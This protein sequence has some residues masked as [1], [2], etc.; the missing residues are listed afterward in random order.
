MIDRRRFITIGV[1]AFVVAGLPV[2]LTRRRQPRT[3][4]RS[5]PVMGT[6]A[7]LVV[8]H[9]DVAKA[10][11]AIDAAVAELR[12]VERTMTR[13]TATSDIGRA[14]AG[15][16]QAAVAVSPETALVV[17][18]ALRWADATSGAYDPAIGGVI[19]LWD[20]TNRQSPP[21]GEAIVAL[22]G[23][24]LHRTVE[25]G[26]GDR[27]YFHDRRARLDLGGI[28]KGYGVDRAVDALRANGI[29]RAV[30]DVGGDLY[31]LG[32]AADDEPWSIGIQSPDDRRALA[33]IIPASDCAIATSGTYQQFFRFR[34]ERYHHLIDPRTAAPRA[35]PVQSLTIR[36]DSCMHADVAATALYGMTTAT[37]N[38]LLARVAF[39]ARVERTI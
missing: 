39:D 32:L 20:V 19:G 2:A 38:A 10:E 34:G 31:A 35:T 36:A 4:R 33:A 25:V 37:A 5:I 16:A 6:I 18:E 24:S 30:V 28:A 11:A 7:E 17:R 14:N 3:I 29:T 8:V 23:L 12:R 27:L 26:S 13:F 22:A 9:D 21:R 1:G 15:A